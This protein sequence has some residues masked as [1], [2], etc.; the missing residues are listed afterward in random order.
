M[1]TIRWKIDS[2]DR[3]SQSAQVKKTSHPVVSLCVCVCVYIYM[4]VCSKI[5]QCS[6]CIMI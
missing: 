3:D 2:H 5:Q 4:Y 1:W 6:S